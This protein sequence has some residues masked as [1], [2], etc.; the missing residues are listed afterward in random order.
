M[1]QRSDPPSK[2]AS[3]TASAARLPISTTAIFVGGAGNIT[4]T[5]GGVEETYTVQAG[6]YLVGNFTHVTAA[7]ATG[8]IA[9]GQ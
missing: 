1:T 7:T 9:V 8:L 4:A 3:F 2:H 6:T 5:L